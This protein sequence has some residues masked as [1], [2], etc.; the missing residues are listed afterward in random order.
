MTYKLDMNIDYNGKYF[1][2]DFINGKAETDNINIVNYFK[3]HNMTVEEKVVKTTKK[4][5]K[6]KEED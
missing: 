2:I 3:R 4:N 6:N 5:T 1:N